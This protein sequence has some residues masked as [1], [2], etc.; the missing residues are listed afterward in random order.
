MQVLG[1]LLYHVVP[2]GA[3]ATVAALDAASPM[4][5]ALGF[6]DTTTQWL[7]TAKSGVLTDGGPRPRATACPAEGASRS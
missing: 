7:L 4:E 6:V 2:T 5:T 3:Y 1:V